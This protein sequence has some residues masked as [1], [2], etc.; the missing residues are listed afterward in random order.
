LNQPLDDALHEK[1]NQLFKEYLLIG[2]MPEAISTWLQTHSLE[3][4][5]QTQQ[6]L[7]H[8]YEDDFSKYT[9]QLSSHYFET[10]F[11]ALPKHLGKKWT[12]SH[13]DDRAEKQADITRTLTLLIKA[14]LC[15]PIQNM[16][17]NGEL[18]GTETD[19]K[20]FKMILIDVGLVSALLGLKLD[21]FKTI[22]DLMFTH[23]DILAEQIVGQLLRLTSPFYIDPFLHYWTHDAYGTSV[24]IDY[25]I[26][27]EQNIVPIQVKAHSMERLPSLHQLMHKKN[28]PC[29]VRFHTGQASSSQIKNPQDHNIRYQLLSLPFYLTEQVHRLL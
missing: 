9:E 20:T 15:H 23:Q 14:R 17:T 22:E 4:L 21:Q 2:G 8:T 26:Q 27:H 6:D 29:I 16:E 11:T 13:I 1:A 10:V 5:R 24:E 25:L 3:A 7:I 18:S 12:Y 28:W 19:S